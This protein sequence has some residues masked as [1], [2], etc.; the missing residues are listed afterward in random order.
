MF[1]NSTYLT[2]VKTLTELR[3]LTWYYDKGVIT[4]KLDTTYIREIDTISCQRQMVGVEVSGWVF[5][6]KGS[7]IAPSLAV[8]CNGII[9]Q[10]QHIIDPGVWVHLRSVFSIPPGRKDINALWL[11]G[12]YAIKDQVNHW[13]GLQ[14][15]LF[16]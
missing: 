13:L 6:E 8:L 5:A 9:E 2:P 11:T 14:V 1:I 3:A 4:I 12:Y 15:R 10:T 16:V 7:C